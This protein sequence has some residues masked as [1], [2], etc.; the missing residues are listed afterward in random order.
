[1]ASQ[2]NRDRIYKFDVSTFKLTRAQ[3]VSYPLPINILSKDFNYTIC[4]VP[5]NLKVKE[6]LN[7]RPSSV[8]TSKRT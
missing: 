1:M 7:E 4:K 3:D 5:Y 6:P 2:Y 8:E